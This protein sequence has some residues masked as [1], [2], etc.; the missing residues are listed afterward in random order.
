[1]AFVLLW[2]HE[3]SSDIF[4]MFS[5]CYPE[6]FPVGCVSAGGPTWQCSSAIP[7]PPCHPWEEAQGLFPAGVVANLISFSHSNWNFPPFPLSLS[8]H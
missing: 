1:M 4:M 3:N 6:Q 7:S 2:S 5:S 8:Y